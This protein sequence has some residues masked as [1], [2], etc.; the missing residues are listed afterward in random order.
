MFCTSMRNPMIVQT[1]YKMNSVGNSV[2]TNGIDT[3]LAIIKQFACSIKLNTNEEAA[4]II[5]VAFIRSG[6]LSASLRFDG[7]DNT[8]IAL[9]GREGVIN[10]SET[11]GAPT[12]YRLRAL[13]EAELLVFQEDL[14][15]DRMLAELNGRMSRFNTSLLVQ[16]SET[17]HANARARLIERLARLILMIK[18]RSDDVELRLTHS[19]LAAILGARRAGVTD[20]L[21][22]LESRR[23]LQSR[24]GRLLVLDREGLIEAAS[25]FYRPAITADDALV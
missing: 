22:L 7:S 3:C 24:R 19:T 14:L 12:T 1:T 4:N 13:Q 16:I 9:I 8:S 23:L 25:G 15:T 2:S 18:D 17:A 21:H 5:G 11:L 6:I 10:F 20:C